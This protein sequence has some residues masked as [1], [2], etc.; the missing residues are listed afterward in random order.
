[1]SLTVIWIHYPKDLTQDKEE[2]F[3][4]FLKQLNTLAITREYPVVFKAKV[5]FPKFLQRVEFAVTKGKAGEIAVFTRKGEIIVMKSTK[6]IQKFIPGF[7]K[8]RPKSERLSTRITKEPSKTNMEYQKGKINSKILTSIPLG[9]Y[10]N[11]NAY[12]LVKEELYNLLET[13][14]GWNFVPLKKGEMPNKSVQDVLLVWVYSGNDWKEDFPA[15]NLLP[16]FNDPLKNVFLMIIREDA[17][18]KELQTYPSEGYGFESP[19]QVVVKPQATAFET[20]PVN[21]LNLKRLQGLLK[22]TIA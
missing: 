5:L 21:I 2:N 18:L 7:T 12:N 8:E 22:K 16:S 19:M 4:G 10:E 17:D 9:D 15:K 3:W 13:Q 11:N 14:L 20:N 6:D 1:M